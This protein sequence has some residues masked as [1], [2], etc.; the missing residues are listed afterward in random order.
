M[1]EFIAV[2]AAILSAVG[3]IYSA[4]TFKR[5]I[6]K[7]SNTYKKLIESYSELIGEDSKSSV[8]DLTKIRKDLEEII[9]GVTDSL[10]HISGKEIHSS[11]K[12]LEKDKEGLNLVTFIR[13]KDSAPYR[14]ILQVKYPVLKNKAYSN[15]FEKIST[16][17][18]KKY[19]LSNDIKDMC[20]GGYFYSGVKKSQWKDIY[21]SVLVVPIQGKKENELIGFVTFDSKDKAAFSRD[22][23]ELASS[24]SKLVSAALSKV[25]SSGSTPEK[26]AQRTNA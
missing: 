25:F 6:D 10:E 12:L 19:Y 17:K 3:A 16:N 1:F 14:E 23:V 13:D 5:Q 21:K 26:N 24:V 9:S 7:V 4:Y 18:G 11:I 8:D 22:S 20:E 15:I 2:V